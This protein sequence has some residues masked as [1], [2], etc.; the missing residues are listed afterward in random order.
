MLLPREGCLQAVCEDG[1]GGN[2]VLPEPTVEVGSG[3]RPLMK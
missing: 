3:G 1:D 2:L